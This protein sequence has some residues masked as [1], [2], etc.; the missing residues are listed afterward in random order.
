MKSPTGLE[1]ILYRFG[2]EINYFIKIS[3][4]QLITCFQL[5]INPDYF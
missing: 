5:K 4:F 2:E 1:N 3:S